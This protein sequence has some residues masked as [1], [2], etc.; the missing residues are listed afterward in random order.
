MLKVK[1]HT[2]NISVFLQGLEQLCRILGIGNDA[3]MPSRRELRLLMA[4]LDT[5]NNVFVIF[6]CS[7]VSIQKL[8]HLFS[9][10]WCQKLDLLLMVVCF[11]VTT[12]VEI[13]VK[14][15]VEDNNN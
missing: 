4:L 9:L 10:V 6:F 2:N 12:A 7:Q 14:D 15:I 13:W 8:Y 5:G 11:Q 3:L 1:T